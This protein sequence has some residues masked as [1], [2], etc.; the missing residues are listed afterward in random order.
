MQ[1]TTVPRL[2]ILLLRDWPHQTIVEGA[3]TALYLTQNPAT[4]E[5]RKELS[6]TPWASGAHLHRTVGDKLYSKLLAFSEWNIPGKRHFHF[7]HVPS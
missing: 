3:I 5:R 6:R 1:C 4:E 2:S 7:M